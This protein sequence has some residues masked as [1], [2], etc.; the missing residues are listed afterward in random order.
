MVSTTTLLIIALIAVFYP[1]VAYIQ[2]DRANYQNSMERQ[3]KETERI[4]K[5]AQSIKH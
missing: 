2:R 1:V 4:H 5:V 3:T